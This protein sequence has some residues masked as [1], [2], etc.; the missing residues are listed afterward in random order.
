MRSVSNATASFLAP[1][2]ETEATLHLLLILTDRG[3]PPL[4]RYRRLVLKIT[5]NM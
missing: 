4:T 2:V 3:D 5:P 1:P